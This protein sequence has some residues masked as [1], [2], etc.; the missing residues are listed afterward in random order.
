[1]QF[2][3]AAA[4]AAAIRLRSVT[5]SLLNC[6]KKVAPSSLL[7][8]NTQWQWIRQRVWVRRDRGLALNNI[9]V[10]VAVGP[11]A[12]G[13]IRP[14]RRSN[15]RKNSEWWQELEG[16]LDEDSSSTG[17]P[18]TL[19]TTPSLLAAKQPRQWAYCVVLLFPGNT[20][21]CRRRRRCHSGIRTLASLTASAVGDDSG[22]SRRQHRRLERQCLVG[23]AVPSYDQTA[24]AAAATGLLRRIPL[25]PTKLYY[26]CYMARTLLMATISP[27]YLVGL[28][29]L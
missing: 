14:N 10:L 26:V 20:R 24:T 1:M 7:L 22:C 19:I 27:V 3:T 23:F 11:T 17:S 25:L 13:S 5:H 18:T 29:D 9:H 2:S 6:R 16:E 12:R 4:E 28:R 21:C 15:T 8:L